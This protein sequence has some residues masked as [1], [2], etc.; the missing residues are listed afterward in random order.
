MKLIDAGLTE[1]PECGTPL[2]LFS[3]GG[4]SKILKCASHPV[5]KFRIELCPLERPETDR[6]EDE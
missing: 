4:L 3:H 6:V 1:C 5:C 2:A